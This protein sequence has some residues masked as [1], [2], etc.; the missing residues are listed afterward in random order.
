MINTL[1]RI[2]PA[3]LLSLSAM[4]VSAEQNIE[5]EQQVTLAV[6][7]QL[8]LPDG[9]AL[10]IVRTGPLTDDLG[11]LLKGRHQLFFTNRTES[12]IPVVVNDI[13]VSPG[14]TVEFTVN[15]SLTSN[16]LYFPIYPAVAGAAGE[17]FYDINLPSLSITN[18]PTEYTELPSNACK[19]V[20][21]AAGEYV[22]PDTYT[23]AGTECSLEKVITINS[24]CP[25]DFALIDGEC[26]KED[27]L[28]ATDSCESGFRLNGSGLCEQNIMYPMEYTCP[29]GYAL[30]NN[31]VC[32][33]TYSIEPGETCSTGYARV[34]DQCERVLE[35]AVGACE[36]GFALESGECFELK[37]P[38]DVCPHGY[39]QNGGNCE[40]LEANT[41]TLDCPA[42][43]ALNA[44]NQ[45]VDRTEILVAGV[46]CPPDAVNDNG[47]CK[48]IE[49]FEQED[50]CPNGQFFDGSKCIDEVVKPIPQC[51]EGWVLID[52]NC[53]E[54]HGYELICPDGFSYADDHCE[55]VDIIEKQ[56]CPDGYTFNESE[57]NCY[58]TIV[59]DAVE[60]CPEEYALVNGQ[61]EREV[62]AEPIG[63]SSG[64]VLNDGRCYDIALVEYVCPDGFTKK[65]GQCE[66]VSITDISSRCP[67]EYK[68][69]NGQCEKL[70]TTD[71]VQSC[72]TSG[73]FIENEECLKVTE[74]AA[75][76]CEAGY[77]MIDGLCYRTQEPMYFCDDDFVLSADNTTCT[78]KQVKDAFQTCP[79]TFENVGGVCERRS[80]ITPELECP[81]G[82]EP[83]NGRCEMQV[84][85]IA[86]QCPE[87]DYYKEDGTCATVK[88]LELTCPSGL[89]LKQGACFERVFS[90]RDS[91]KTG[92]VY[93]N[94]ECFEVLGKEKVCEAGEEAVT[95]GGNILCKSLESKTFCADG[96]YYDGNKCVNGKGEVQSRADYCPEGF[97]YTNDG[98]EERCT[99]T[100]NL[101]LTHASLSCPEGASA[102]TASDCFSICPEGFQDNNGV[103]ESVAK[104]D[105]ESKVC[106]SGELMDGRCW[107]SESRSAGVSGFICPVGTENASPYIDDETKRRGYSKSCLEQV[108][109]AKEEICMS[110]LGVTGQACVIN[111]TKEFVSAE[112]CPDGFAVNKQGECTVVESAQVSCDGVTFNGP[113]S[114]TIDTFVNENGACASLVK[115]EQQEAYVCPTGFKP[116]YN[117][118]GH[119]LPAELNPKS[120]V[121]EGVSGEVWAAFEPQWSSVNFVSSTSDDEHQVEGTPKVKDFLCVSDT[122]T[123]MEANLGE[124]AEHTFNAIFAGTKDYGID[125][126]SLVDNVTSMSTRYQNDYVSGIDDVSEIYNYEFLKAIV[127]G[128]TK[129]SI[130][131]FAP[132]LSVLNG[133]ASAFPAPGTEEVKEFIKLYPV[134]GYEDKFVIASMLVAGNVEGNSP[135]AGEYVSRA[136]E[137]NAPSV[138]DIVSGC[139]VNSEELVQNI[140]T[141]NAQ[142]YDFIV[143]AGGVVIDTTSYVNEK[144][145]ESCF[146]TYQHQGATAKDCPVGMKMNA[147]GQCETLNGFPQAQ[148][149]ETVSEVRIDYKCPNG[150]QLASDGK[151]CI[152]K[153]YSPAYSCERGE[154]DAET[155]LCI[156]QFQCESGY[157]AVGNTCTKRIDCDDVLG[158]P[159]S[160]YDADYLTC[161]NDNMGDPV[162]A[163]PSCDKGEIFDPARLMCVLTNDKLTTPA[164]LACDADEIEGDQCVTEKRIPS[165]ESKT[166]ELSEYNASTGQCDT[167][168]V[169]GHDASEVYCDTARDPVFLNGQW[170]CAEDEPSDTV[171]PVCPS[172]YT[173]SSAG[174]STCVRDKY[175]KPQENPVQGG[176]LLNGFYVAGSSDANAL[177]CS[178]ETFWNGSQCEKLVESA[179]APSIGAC[180]GVI[181]YG[182]D[183]KG[184]KTQICQVSSQ[185][186]ICEAGYTMGEEGVCERVE[187][188][189][190]TNICPDDFTFDGIHCQRLETE[191]V[192]FSCPEDMTM[193]SPEEGCESIVTVPATV[194]CPEG[195]TL[196]NGTCINTDTDDFVAMCDAPFTY[197]AINNNCR[198][199]EI[200]PIVYDCGPNQTLNGYVCEELLTEQIIEECPTQF[201]QDGQCR[202]VENLPMIAECP[203]GYTNSG[204]NC[205]STVDNTSAVVCPNGTSQIA[206]SSL[207]A[208]TETTGIILSCPAPYDLKNGNECH[209][210]EIES[211][212]DECP[213]GYRLTEDGRC[214]RITVASS[215]EFCASGYT[216]N[217]TNKRCERLVDAPI[218]GCP[219]NFVLQSGACYPLYTSQLDCPNNYTLNTAGRCVNEAVSPLDTL[220]PSGWRAGGNGECYQVQTT[221]GAKK[222]PS[223]FYF[224]NGV[225]VEDIYK[226]INGC[227]DGFSFVNGECRETSPVLYD[228][229]AGWETNGDRCERTLFS[230]IDNCP[231]GYIRQGD[232]C[233]AIQDADES[234]PSGYVNG[235]DGT[236]YRDET[237]YV[238]S[239]PSGYVKEGNYCRRVIDANESCPSGYSNG[240]DGKC[241]RDESTLI[242]SCPSGYV[243]Q[244][245]YCYRVFNA[246]ENCPSGYT[247]G[248]DGK[249]YSEQATSVSSCPSGYVKQGS[250]CH[251]VINANMNCPSGYSRS[252]TTCRKNESI[253]ATPVC[254]SGYTRSGTT[255]SKTETI[256]AT[257][258]CPSGYT[259]SGTTCSKTETISATPNCP[260]GY[261]RSGSTCSKTETIPA[262]ASCPSGY[263]RSGTTCSK[264][265]TISATASCPSGY[266]KSGT[267]CTRQLS[268]SPTYSCPSGYSRSGSTCRRTSTYSATESCPIGS[269]PSGQSRCTASETVTPISQSCFGGAAYSYDASQD[270]YICQTGQP[271]NVQCPDGTA[272]FAQ[273][274]CY[275]EQEVSP[276]YSCPSG[277]TYT[278]NGTCTKT[279]TRRANQSCPS[280][281]TLSNGT[282]KKTEQISLTYSCPSGYTKSGT[283]CTRT[284]TQPVTYS[285]PSGYTK[286][287][288]SCTRTVSQPVTYSCPSGYTKSGSTCSRTLTQTV[289]YS[290]PSGYTKSGS[291]CSRTLTQPV[292]YQCPSGYT[293][294]GTSCDRTLTEGV[295]YACPSGYSLY[296]STK[297]KAN[298]PTY[299][300]GVCPSGYSL[301]TSNG[302]CER[303]L[304]QNVTFS[305]PSG[306]SI[307]NTDQC[308][309]NGPVYSVGNCPAGGWSLNTSNGSCERTLVEA[310]L[311]FCNS[312]YSLYNSVDCKR[313]TPTYSVG[314]CPSGGWS[315]NT[316]TGIC[317]RTLTQAVT[318]YCGTSGYSIFNTDQCK[319]NSPTYSVGSCPTGYN[320]NSSTGTCER[321][322]N[323]AA[324]EYC[325]T[326]NE[327]ESINCPTQTCDPGYTLTGGQCI[328]VNEFPIASCDSGYVMIDNACYRTQPLQMQCPAGY[329]LQNGQCVNTEVQAGLKTCG[330]GFALVG[331]SCYELL[332]KVATCP[333][334]YQLGDGICKRGMTQSPL[335]CKSGYIGSGSTC[336]EIV[337][338]EE[339]CPANSTYNSTEGKCVEVVTAPAERDEFNNWYCPDGELDTLGSWQN[340]C[341]IDIVLTDPVIS[342]PSG[343]STLNGQCAKNAYDANGVQC[344]TNYVFDSTSGICRNIVT[345]DPVDQCPSGT[346][347][348]SSTQ[349]R[350]TTSQSSALICG[351]NAT[352]NPSTGECEVESTAEPTPSCNNGYVAANGKCRAVDSTLNA[353][354][355]P[356]GMSLK[357]DGYCDQVL[358][359]ATVNTCPDGVTGTMSQ[360]RSTTGDNV[361]LCPTGYTF[362][363]DRCVDTREYA[364]ILSCPDTHYFAS[365]QCFPMA[366]SFNTCPSG[367][368]LNGEQCEKVS[369]S[370]V[371]TNCR[372]GFVNSNGMCVKETKRSFVDC[373]AG[374]ALSNDGPFKTCHKLADSTPTC[375]P[376]SGLVNGMCVSINVQ[377][378]QK[379]C[380]DGYSQLN[381]TTCFKDLF[382]PRFFGC[383]TSHPET[384]VPNRTMCT[385]G[386]TQVMRQPTCPEDTVY[387]S[388]EGMCRERLTKPV[389][390]QCPLDFTMDNGKCVKEVSDYPLKEVSCPTGYKQRVG[391]TEQCQSLADYPEKGLCPSG[392]KREGSVCVNTESFEPQQ[393][394]P[395]GFAKVGDSCVKSQVVEVNKTCRIGNALDIHYCREL[396][397]VSDLG[398]N[399]QYDCPTGYRARGQS[400]YRLVKRPIDSICASGQVITPEGCRSINEVAHTD[401]CPSGQTLLSDGVCRSTTP[402]RGAGECGA[403]FVSTGDGRCYR[404]DWQPPT[405][406]CSVGD[407]QGLNCYEYEDIVAEPDCPYGYQFNGSQCQKIEIENIIKVCKT[408]FGVLNESFCREMVSTN[409]Q[410]NCGV[411]AFY[412]TELQRC[413]ERNEFPRSTNCPSGM[414]FNQDTGF[415]QSVTVVPEDPLNGFVCPSGYW[416]DTARE[417]CITYQENVANTLFTCPTGYSIHHNEC[418]KTANVNATYACPEDTV[419]VNPANKM[420]AYTAL[421]LNLGTCPT[422]FTYNAS[423][424]ICTSDERIKAEATC[425]DD[426]LLTSSGQCRRTVDSVPLT[427][428][429]NS[430]Y[431]NVEGYL[432][433]VKEVTAVATPSCPS[434]FVYHTG[435]SRC[436]DE[437]IESKIIVCEN[438]YALN[439]ENARCEKLISTP[440]DKQCDDRFVLKNGQCVSVLPNE[441]VSICDAGYLYD[442][443]S[444][445]CVQ[446][447]VTEIVYTCPTDYVFDDA[448]KACVRTDDKNAIEDCPTGFVLTS[449]KTACSKTKEVAAAPACPDNYELNGTECTLVIKKAPA[450]TCPDNFTKRGINEC[451]S[452]EEAN[453]I[454][455]CGEGYDF[456][457]GQCTKTDY[458]PVE[459][460]AA[461]FRV[462]EGG[463]Y[464]TDLATFDCPA[465][466]RVTRN[467]DD[468]LVCR[469]YQTLSNTISCPIGQYSWIKQG[470]VDTETDEL[471][472][473][474]TPMCLPVEFGEDELAQGEFD[475]TRNRCI[476]QKEYPAIDYMN[477]CSGDLIQH[478]EVYCRTVTA[479]NEKVIPPFGY[480]YDE[481]TG[482]VKKE[483]VSSADIKCH[484]GFSLRGDT[485][486]KEIVVEPTANV[487]P[488]GFSATG[489][490]TCE[491]SD[492]MEAMFV[493]PEGYTDIGSNQCQRTIILP[494]L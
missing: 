391:Q 469:F 298:S 457:D 402:N 285:C 180:E 48:K 372:D 346:T 365:G 455:L 127:R 304:V 44:D 229:P 464:E 351:S 72:A 129:V 117:Y 448:L 411:N 68:E 447:Q 11:N 106:L 119:A 479:D 24:A 401:R 128:R 439:A 368:S 108:T 36:A 16:R 26:V 113:N 93:S 465:G 379:V 309:S 193:I 165:S 466:T 209:R 305:C 228:C 220:C 213:A 459:R 413:V 202:K 118:D 437:N 434:G 474:S 415:C 483:L 88:D 111:G 191:E 395:N 312:G 243:K 57:Q 362:E 443:E 342:C 292:T 138:V 114:S 397:S 90:E 416:Y 67:D 19:K 267:K 102:V 482:Y 299:S 453:P 69:V 177:M 105:Y 366:T 405:V 396:S 107:V 355:C 290:C 380:Y 323:E 121:N 62:T 61:C 242:A 322:E 270:L 300:I 21:V 122:V 247:N 98:G 445:Q 432:N 255:C 100:D 12:T 187:I 168:F 33:R 230:P 456:V 295:T 360:C 200:E 467:G 477:A 321:D 310:V 409:I 406:T 167:Y 302:S 332:N 423:M 42:G 481:L 159:G 341:V 258:N 468:D 324:T 244:G 47:V 211:S 34:G 350:K 131:G 142:L 462:I 485:C 137:A 163:P 370:N 261:T 478:D 427:K 441:S 475:K 451:V 232:F 71:A 313:T 381:A 399:Y 388:G 59:G 431:Q 50:K 233:Y 35:L 150:S 66:K 32:K 367:Y 449:D 18:C 164:Q 470:C 92:F 132:S 319:R 338:G 124:S 476:H 197:D 307:Y 374:Y 86:S 311:Y 161:R 218:A 152:T 400:C 219:T 282:C 278:G 89:I 178:G 136:I 241:Y 149:C 80:T 248:G 264:T 353:G 96:F 153:A 404:I 490:D 199:E 260:S 325:T 272:G 436:V 30:D 343:A 293:L 9:S 393:S 145:E 361:G 225:C 38:L 359:R 196:T 390:T 116:V 492:T 56:Q 442:P 418:R 454:V 274:N 253:S 417:V 328:Q 262:T 336:R 101:T 73:Y 354:N 190:V 192:V 235:N 175:T 46:A 249:C 287:G 340:R 239:C 84:K 76:Q 144:S 126:E 265:E 412:S 60:S 54:K 344:P 424:R 198:L 458:K 17:I 58:K 488:T 78:K 266:I 471:I 240:G 95:M 382:T 329:E 97:I 440:V 186:A 203:L 166:F 134:K 40:L 433:C 489:P 331:G 154:Y 487:C 275:Q 364:G 205:L 280:G 162:A 70:I 65:A 37:V 281:Y 259:R 147:I 123:F 63:C 428:E 386:S 288:T 160:Y 64:H 414:T 3:V 291:T 303:T 425:P 376:N 91:C 189:E 306:Y 238:A 143:S 371:T 216:F 156:E 473:E 74:A 394:C 254:P 182:F 25:L 139:S 212:K 256:S 308:R 246:T 484:D 452:V 352:F 214:E 234:C 383:P 112:V 446:H 493:C 289:A 369:S 223:G 176:Q 8:E 10:S 103:C 349:C 320:L 217:D 426:A 157:E 460:C 140:A 358:T 296:S 41:P 222:C 257:P 23:N 356:S 2:L 204:A 357:S 491:M 1:K 172:G 115:V 181:E 51:Q 155:G 148:S 104:V 13:N 194:Q 173:E 7:K 224:E 318:Y 174:S 438:G 480:E 77:T 407:L 384:Y 53:Y 421:D 15:L 387:D 31:N 183:A 378:V 420:C 316:S 79:E 29:D 377:D 284:V 210:I 52:G 179:Q 385:N 171:V 444:D 315:L 5:I 208:S 170:Y 429:C 85:T 435:I 236:C 403:G 375:P 333:A 158:M 392:M 330:E 133:S 207:C 283:S 297:C 268:T 81:V 271:T 269:F 14:E 130:N 317:E 314:I 141:Y 472:T 110:D 83:A 195:E 237:S 49:L 201:V 28:T 277:G 251:R 99:S 337:E 348:Y 486:E 188:H 109:T 55:R 326:G 231:S 373:E 120:I 339:E 87:G 45:C 245:D 463:C 419:M 82:Y 273:G 215:S 4:G 75:K 22:C 125:G 461:G 450:T 146:I 6:D 334:N 422:G 294:N 250:Y 43:Y 206:G 430:P 169:Q 252:G 279:E 301:N 335:G 227:P 363:N 408:E 327:L 494:A 184:A 286:S 151:S 94:G 276:E 39:T 226:N 389:I 345:A 185:P 135:D 347:S 263:T 221:S 20:E 398:F 410:A 27:N